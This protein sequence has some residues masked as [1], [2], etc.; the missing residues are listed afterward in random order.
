LLKFSDFFKTIT[1]LHLFKKSLRLLLLAALFFY[2]A[3]AATMLTV[4]YLVLP[5]IN[6]WRPMLEQRLSQELGSSVMIG[7]ISANWS[8]LNPTLA[9]TDLN[10]ATPE[11]LTL[12]SIPQAFAVVSWGSVFALDVR[13]KLLEISGIDVT[14]ERLPDG[15]L[16]IAGYQIDSSHPTSLKL[17]TDTLAVRWLL[18]QGKILVH[19][20]TVRWVDSQRGAPELKL[21]NV[22]VA[23]T[24]GL[25]S[26]NFLVRASAPNNIAKSVELIIRSNQILSR[27]GTNAARQAEV[28]LEVEDVA[29]QALAPW[30]DLPVLKGRYAARAWVD[31][32]QGAFGMA[33]VQLSGAKVGLPVTPDAAGM[34]AEH[35]QVHV[36]GLLGDMLPTLHADVLPTSANSTPLNIH[37][38]LSGAA[39][40]S[41]L[42]EPTFL[43]LG[44]VELDVQLKLASPT[45]PTNITNT[46][47]TVVPSRSDTAP[48]IASAHISNLT[49]THPDIA[50]TWQGDWHAGGESAAGIADMKGTISSLAAPQLYRY[51]STA[52]NHEARNWLRDALVQGEF[53]QVAVTLQGDLFHF[54]FNLPNETGV[55]RI[56]GAFNHLSLDYAPVRKDEAGWPALV[57]AQGMIVIDK[58]SLQM[59]SKV[60]N[61]VDVDGALIHVQDLYARIAD[62]SLQPDLTIDMTLHGEA[63]NFLKAM[64]ESPV[65]ERTG[66]F[67]NTLEATDFFQVPVSIHAELNDMQALQAK[68]QVNFAGNNV[69][70]GKDLPG[71]EHVEGSLGFAN[72]ALQ[73][74]QLKAKF[75]GEPLVIQGSLGDPASKGLTIDGILSI[76]SL[77]PL[78]KSPAL[79]ALDGRTKFSAQVNQNNKEGVDVQISS[80][81][82]GLS[83]ALPAPVGKPALQKSSLTFKWSSTKQRQEYRHS[84]FFNLGDLITGKLERQ[85]EKRST[86]F[87]TQAAIGMGTALEIPATGMTIDLVLGEVDWK[88]WKQLSD[89]VSQDPRRAAKPAQALLPQL[90]RIAL[91]TP[92]LIFDDLTFSDL[93]LAIQ[94]AEKGSWTAK[95]DSKETEGRIAWQESSGAIAGRVSAQFSK[96]ELGQPITDSD[97]P[98]KIENINEK[99]WSDIPAVDLRIDDFTLFGSRL[100]A[101]HLNGDNIERGDHWNIKSLELKNPHATLSATGEWRLKGDQRGVQLKADLAVTDLGKLTSYMGYP[102][103]V[104]EG[105]G[106]I[107]A[108]VDW[109]NFP[110][111][112][113]YEGMSG[114]ANVELK[115]GVFEHVNSRSARL[116]ELLSLQSLQR[117]LSFNF[118]PSNEFKDGFPFNSVDGSFTITRGVAATKDLTIASPVAS[119]LLVGNSDLTNKTWNMDADVKP[120]FDMSGTAVATG[121]VV[122]PLVGLS[123]LVTQF[124]LR[125]PIERAMTAKYQVRGPWDDPT[126]IPL[127]I[128]Q[129]TPSGITRNPGP[130][131]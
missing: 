127:E 82:E 48:A 101:L 77:G 112:F 71:L 104:R 126:L 105:S 107:K 131:N 120:R 60:S 27:L 47:N 88:D 64:R 121:F 46:T 76:A 25:F 75:L 8:G 89:Q 41:T 4:R 39:L 22:D 99:Q 67:F 21:T 59:Q 10:V 61:L 63:K 55:F 117:I 110:W 62:M 53:S 43:P 91:R 15:N 56:Q 100:G 52:T 49:I 97:A 28:F 2:I 84:V 122:N 37:A 98:P 3:A 12:L 124:L 32:Q 83:I 7:Q 106:D 78:T 116:L 50:L 69:V 95:M 103:K 45:S 11:G 19:D 51:L 20:S 18:D 74:D 130:G 115:E 68:G 96:L 79:L 114:T 118:R 73:F 94:Q 65:N 125:N 80:S 109:K 33:E 14:A 44:A 17:N 29:P 38:A 26:H 24:N 1:V 102:D 85:P 57:D 119:I 6:V 111:V 16:K 9:I 92:R 5:Q 34:F 23:L 128:T 58:L 86:S 81:L 70:W 113:S 40:D 35:A 90:T 36:T 31:I 93:N 30:I 123:A 72:G 66:Q 129:P 54:P 13:F 108:E 87:F 42:F